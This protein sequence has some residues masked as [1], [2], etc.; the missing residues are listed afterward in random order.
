MKKI[1]IATALLTP[2][3]SALAGQ[4]TI[5]S[6]GDWYQVQNATTYVA[7]CEGNNGLVCEIPDGTI[8]K[9]TNFS[10]ASSHPD[11]SRVETIGEAPETETPALELIY[12]RAFANDLYT[13]GEFEGF[14]VPC[15][16]GSYAISMSCSVYAPSDAEFHDG[17]TY[18]MDVQTT[19]SQEG[20]GC[21][22]AGDTGNG[23]RGF[24]RMDAMVVCAVSV[25]ASE[26]PAID[27]SR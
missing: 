23:P 10:V 18:P 17:S 14:F 2:P 24:G 13:G 8:V 25:S 7:Y 4:F 15:P 12:Q 20:G 11:R 26:L 16:E 5:P 6:D 22:L 1:L 19:F 21:V 27:M 9:I 3:L